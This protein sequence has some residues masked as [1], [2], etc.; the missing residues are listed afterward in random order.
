MAILISNFFLCVFWALL[1]YSLRLDKKRQI[2]LFSVICVVQVSLVRGLAD[3][4]ALP[5]LGEYMD[6]YKSVGDLGIDIF[7]RDDYENADM[8]VGYKAINWIGSC[9]SF[10]FQ[11]LL[12]TIS[13]IMSILYVKW[14]RSYSPYLW[15]SFLIMLLI[16]YNQSLFVIRQN[17]SMAIVVCS[18]KYILREDFKSFVK[19]ILIASIVHYSSMVFLP[20][21]FVYK[22]KNITNYI[23]VLCIIA[24]AMPLVS[25]TIV[26][27]VA[28]NIP[29]LSA[30]GAVDMMKFSSKA[31]IFAIVILSYLIILRKRCFE[32]GVNKLIFT[33]SMLGFIGSS[34]VGEAGSGR[35]FQTYWTVLMIQIPWVAY[36]IKNKFLR[37]SY[38]IGILCAFY[39]FAYYL[40]AEVEWVSDFKLII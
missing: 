6:F 13:F 23:K 10:S 34:C 32:V 31:A 38:V 39:L 30:Y 22:I 2:F 36:Y 33:I 19:V 37:Y 40:S 28:A 18:Y 4:T 24:I 15:L 35:I 12:I 3:I 25:I 1:I 29:A 9:V 11:F 16:S 27:F 17:L 26:R 14:F 7:T 5:D 21:Y 20:V 8:E